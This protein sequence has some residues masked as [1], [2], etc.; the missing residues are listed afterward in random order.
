MHEWEVDLT[1]I[2]GESACDQYGPED[3]SEEQ[4]HFPVCWVVRAHDLQLGVEVQGKEDETGKCGSSVAGR[5][6][7]EG[8]IDRFLVSGADRPVI[9]VIR[10]LRPRG[11]GELSYVR[12]TNRVEMGSEAPDQPFEPD[13]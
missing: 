4:Y 10:E 5:E 9:H 12:H 6:R 2:D 7:L 11:L 1:L 3:G 13:L 8:I